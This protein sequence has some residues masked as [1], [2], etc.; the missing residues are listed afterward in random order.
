MSFSPVN[1]AVFGLGGIG[2]T[3]LAIEYTYRFRDRYHAVPWVSADSRE[4][5]ITGCMEL[6]TELKL[7]EREERDQNKIV[8]ALQRWLCEQQGWLLILDNV[9]DLGLVTWFLPVQHQGVVLLTTRRQVT[10]PVAQTMVMDVP[11]E[12]EGVLFLLRRTKFLPLDGSLDQVVEADRQ[13]AHMI[14]RTLGGLPLA[15][16]QAG[17]YILETGCDL[18]TYLPSTSSGRP[19]CCGGEEVF[20]LI[21]HS[22]LRPPSLWPLRR[23]GEEV[24]RRLNCYG[25]VPFLL[26]MPL[27]RRSSPQVLPALGEYCSQWQRTHIR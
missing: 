10:E 19:S 15:L 24:K 16:D 9:E 27:P 8:A 23:C 25:S 5:L 11:P 12:E 13:T 6:A 3:Q 7:P 2:K 18:A 26:P 21:I 4:T 22:R 20:L 17:A 14:A 1:G